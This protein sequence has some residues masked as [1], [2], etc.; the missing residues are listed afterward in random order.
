MANPGAIMHEIYRAL[1]AVG[2]DWKTISAY[3][4][5]C[6][7]EDPGA[8][9]EHLG[10]EEPAAGGVAGGVLSPRVLKVALQLYKLPDGQVLPAQQPLAIKIK[11]LVRAIL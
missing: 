4:L 6:R 2:F 8:L 3:S 11:T 7:Y 9:G 5:K 1:A 10:A